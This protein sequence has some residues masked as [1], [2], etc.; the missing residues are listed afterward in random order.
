MVRRSGGVWSRFYTTSW[1]RLG[2]SHCIGR[3]RRQ[4][5]E[6]F[7]A[8][9]KLHHWDANSELRVVKSPELKSLGN[10]NSSRHRCNHGSASSAWKYA[11]NDG[12][13]GARHHSNPAVACPTAS[14]RP[15]AVL[16]YR[17]PWRLFS[18]PPW[19]STPSRTGRPPCWTE[20]FPVPTPA[21]PISAQDPRTIPADRNDPTDFQQSHRSDGHHVGS[22][23][24]P[25]K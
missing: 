13:V 9:K 16:R 17:P 22:K 10:Q 6:N 3:K 7:S 20:D 8:G 21:P 5:K 23:W 2:F 14:L 4:L 1:H 11:A 18:S 24:P 15:I 25:L 12:A 19:L